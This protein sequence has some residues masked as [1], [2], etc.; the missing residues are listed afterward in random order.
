MQRQ[1]S[2]QKVKQARPNWG[3]FLKTTEVIN[4]HLSK[5]RLKLAK[6]TLK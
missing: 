4:F 5:I 3:A 6:S 1:I 2:V